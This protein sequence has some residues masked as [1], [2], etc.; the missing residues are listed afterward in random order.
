M[1]SRE[2]AADDGRDAPRH[3]DKVVLSGEICRLGAVVTKQWPNAGP[4]REHSGFPVRSKHAQR[5]EQILGFI[6]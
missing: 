1:K 5:L 2:L 6:R 3:V 4:C